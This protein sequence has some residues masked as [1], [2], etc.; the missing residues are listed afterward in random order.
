MTDKPARCPNPSCGSDMVNVSYNSELEALKVTCRMCDA[1]S[2]WHKTTGNALDAWAKMGAWRNGGWRDIETA[3]KDG[4]YIIVAQEH[5][6]PDVVLWLPE[7]KERVVGGNRVIGR[8]AGWF[9]V[10]RSRIKAP[11]HW[12]P[13]PTPPK[14]G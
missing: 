10:S 12:Q 9:N 3:P 14:E 4:T 6:L 13:L 5:I 1:A 8:P 7:Q 2:G 11:T